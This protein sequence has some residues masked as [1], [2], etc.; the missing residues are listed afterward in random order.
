MQSNRMKSNHKGVAQ[1]GDSK[2]L[3]KDNLVWQRVT[4]FDAQGKPRS[5]MGWVPKSN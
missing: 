2:F 4:Y 3:N 5:I 1:R